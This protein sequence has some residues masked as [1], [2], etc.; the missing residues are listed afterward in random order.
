MT[1]SDLRALPRFVGM[2]CLIIRLTE[3]ETWSWRKGDPASEALKEECCVLAR[4][5][6]KQVH[7]AGGDRNPARGQP[8]LPRGSPD[9]PVVVERALSRPAE[10]NRAT[11][12]TSPGVLTKDG[13]RSGGVI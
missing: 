9:D 1:L 13:R 6:S 5:L 8:R 3:E 12:A 7:V 11:W 2:E 10:S 4:R